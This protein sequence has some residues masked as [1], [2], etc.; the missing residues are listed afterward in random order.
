LGCNSCVDVA[1]CRN[2][3]AVHSL[4]LQSAGGQSLYFFDYFEC[5]L[6]SP[7]VHQYLAV[8]DA[9]PAKIQRLGEVYVA[10]VSTHTR[11]TY[12]TCYV[13]DWSILRSW[14]VQAFALLS[15]LWYAPRWFLI[16][17]SLRDGSTVCIFLCCDF[18]F[19]CFRF[20]G[21][22]IY[23]LYA[24]FSVSAYIS[25]IPIHYPSN[26]TALAFDISACVA[27]NEGNNQGA[28]NPVT[29]A[30]LQCVKFAIFAK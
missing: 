27:P 28:K 24:Y 22:W 4:A 7:A 1:S 14:P 15:L 17:Q 12:F 21:N 23:L 25:C 11:L 30:L 9:K 18:L 20:L 3:R 5:N 29:A 13:R 26:F 10:H 2:Q 19:F 6:V 8:S 16:A